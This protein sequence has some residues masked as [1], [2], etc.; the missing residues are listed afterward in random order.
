[1]A[2]ILLLLYMIKQGDVAKVSTYFYLV[3]PM[4]AIEAWFLFDE[5]LSL[6]MMLGMLLCA[7]SV[8]LVVKKTNKVSNAENLKVGT[9]K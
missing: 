9:V 3:P 1:M 6:V 8:F 7:I 2:A 5:S 4:T